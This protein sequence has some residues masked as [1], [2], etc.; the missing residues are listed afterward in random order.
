MLGW[1]WLNCRIEQGLL[2]GGEKPGAAS[3][4][5]TGTQFS[6]DLGAHLAVTLNSLVLGDNV[7]FASV[8]L[9]GIVSLEEE[10]LYVFCRGTEGSHTKVGSQL[11]SGWAGTGKRN[12]YY[13]GAESLL[14]PHIDIRTNKS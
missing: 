11:L 9:V 12:M 1:E 5:S 4:A 8:I 6:A 13:R 7:H 14:G 10:Y 3:T 2:R